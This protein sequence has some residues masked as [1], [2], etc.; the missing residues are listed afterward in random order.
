VRLWGKRDSRFARGKSSPPLPR[1]SLAAMGGVAKAMMVAGGRDRGG[2]GGKLVMATISA[3]VRLLS[4][5][6]YMVRSSCEI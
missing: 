2:G 5:I 6:E 3:T 4:R 1:G